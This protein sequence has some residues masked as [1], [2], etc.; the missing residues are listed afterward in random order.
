MAEEK[1]DAEDQ[2]SASDDH[3]NAH[4]TETN[5]SHSSPQGRR[6]SVSGKGKAGLCRVRL[7][8][9]TDYETEMDVSFLVGNICSIRKKH[10]NRVIFI[11]FVISLNLKL[12]QL[13]VS[14][15]R[16]IFKKILNYAF[17]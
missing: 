6:L 5:S 15:K 2:K 17:V 14:H 12:C 9:G 8:D 16:N 1:G 13:I 11:Y 7:L 4:E 3:K 10:L